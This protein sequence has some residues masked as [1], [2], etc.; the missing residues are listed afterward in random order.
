MLK[1]KESE[2]KARIHLG[3]N[4]VIDIVLAAFFFSSSGIWTKL[5]GQD[6]FVLS[7]LEPLYRF[8]LLVC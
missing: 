3:I 1:H 2:N 7:F 4:P 6:A 8:F 5:S